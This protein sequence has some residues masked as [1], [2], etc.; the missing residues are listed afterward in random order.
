MPRAPTASSAAPSVKGR[1][2]ET[3]YFQFK[4]AAL[5]NVSRETSPKEEGIS[6]QIGD[7]PLFL[8]H[9]GLPKHGPHRGPGAKEDR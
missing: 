7:S 4:M 3:A 5:K 8:S 6:V 2:L 9:D 1:A